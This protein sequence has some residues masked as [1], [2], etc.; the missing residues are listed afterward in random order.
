LVEDDVSKDL[1]S[2]F[3]EVL[4]GEVL[5]GGSSVRGDDQTEL[6]MAE[7]NALTNLEDA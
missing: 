5:S 6:R 4:R 1:V 7:R 3:R 2:S